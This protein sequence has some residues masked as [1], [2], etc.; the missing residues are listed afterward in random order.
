MPKSSEAH[1]TLQ[2][3]LRC[4]FSL[5]KNGACVRACSTVMMRVTARAGAD[6]KSSRQTG[7][8]PSSSSSTIPGSSVRVE[9]RLSAPLSRLPLMLR[10]GGSMRGWFP[11]LLSVLL[12]GLAAA[13][14]SDLF[15]N[16]LGDINYCKKQCQLTIK[17]KSPAKVSCSRALSC[18]W[19]ERHWLNAGTILII[20]YIS[21]ATSAYFITSYFREL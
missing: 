11:A 7:P 20:T 4:R 14:S 10:F 9:G 1:Y 15:D 21:P 3:K 17:N 6:R 8:E 13:T 5:K 16:Q 12:S 18:L 19:K 2:W